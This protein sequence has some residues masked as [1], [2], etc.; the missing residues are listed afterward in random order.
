M[1]FL[2][3]KNNNLS[4]LLKIS[5]SEKNYIRKN[6]FKKIILNKQDQKKIIIDK[7]PL[8]IIELGFIKIIFS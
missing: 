4:N 6:Y 5:E 8:S 7:L 2:K 1:N 3:N